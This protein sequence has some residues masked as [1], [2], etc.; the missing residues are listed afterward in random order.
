MSGMD[1]EYFQQ[2]WSPSQIL[3]E[4]QRIG[5]EESRR[6]RNIAGAKRVREF[7]E[8]KRRQA[9]AVDEFLEAFEHFEHGRR[10]A[11]LSAEVRE[12]RG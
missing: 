1:R 5:A 10:C 11:E 12:W 4:M 9:I 8:R 6:L 3:E 2:F 7:R